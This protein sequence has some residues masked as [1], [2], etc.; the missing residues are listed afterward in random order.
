[1]KIS[2]FTAKDMRQALKLVRDQLGTEAVILTSK[3]T[4]FGVEVTAAIDFDAA[5]VEQLATNEVL[6]VAN[7]LA[8]GQSRGQPPA[9]SHGQA[10]SSAHAQLQTNAHTQSN[11][12]ARGQ[13]VAGS[14]EPRPFRPEEFAPQPVAPSR[15]APARRAPQPEHDPYA[16]VHQDDYSR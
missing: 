4:P 2:R 10:H 14:H 6:A 9:Q 11:A 1:M 3:R 8:Q 7:G 12:Q 15:A 5:R 16:D 13:A